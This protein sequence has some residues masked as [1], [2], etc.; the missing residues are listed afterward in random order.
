MK[1]NITKYI[2]LLLIAF[3]YCYTPAMAKND[4]LQKTKVIV[5]DSSIIAIRKPSAEK[6]NELLNNKDYQYERKSPVG[7]NP[8]ERF[9]EWLANQLDKLFSSKGGEISLNILKYALIIA[10]IVTIVFILLKN[11]VRSLFYGKSAKTII[12][13][14]ELEED[15]HK[16]D[17]N[18]LISKAIYEKDYRRA[19]RLHF[20]KLL[21]EL[22]DKNLIA[23]KIDKTNKDYYIELSNTSYSKQFNELT[24]LYEYIWYGNFEL[25]EDDYNTTINKFKSFRL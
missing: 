19:V 3:C 20:L 7:K 21:K 11:N 13:Y 8:W 25:N 16:I 14:S 24:F 4:S 2:I 1:N 5:I 18:E 22:T 6:Q 23:W 9:K 12:D 15:I 17:F 10:A